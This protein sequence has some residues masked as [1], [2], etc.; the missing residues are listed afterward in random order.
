MILK[1]RLKANET[2]PEIKV[3]REYGNLPQ[4]E[5]Y[6]GQLNQVFMNLLGNAIDALDESNQGQNYAEIANQI[7]I[8]TEFYEHKKQAIIRIKDNGVGMSEAVREKIFED[9]FTTKEVG[10]GTGLGLAIAWHI[11][12]E[13]HSGMLEVSFTLGRGTEFTIS[14]PC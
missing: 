10:K 1:H 5:C 11:V 12:V 7:T 2:R 14:I 9:L 6:A 4:V 3:I 13:K 8:K